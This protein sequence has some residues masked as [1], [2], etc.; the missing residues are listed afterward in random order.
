MK[1][2]PNAYNSLHQGKYIFSE[3][4]SVLRFRCSLGEPCVTR[5]S[6]FDGFFS[7]GIGCW[8]EGSEK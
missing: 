4:P 3:C 8:C 1:A 2:R 6:A 7:P 5:I